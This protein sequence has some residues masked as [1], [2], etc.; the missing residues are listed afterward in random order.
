MHVGLGVV[1]IIH[2]LA[3]A[4]WVGGLI[5]LGAVVVPATR[6]SM[7]KSPQARTVLDAIQKRLTSFVYTS[8]VLLVASGLLLARHSPAFRGFFS[9]QNPYSALLA[10]KHL[11][12]VLMIAIGLFRSL[13]LVRPRAPAG[14]EPLKMGLLY[15]NMTLGLFVLI[16]SGLGAALAGL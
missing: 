15:V 12:V 3:T 13:V 1:K 5:V 14:R 11:L 8:M 9:F 6:A 10:V 2:D 7:G 16:L 4:V